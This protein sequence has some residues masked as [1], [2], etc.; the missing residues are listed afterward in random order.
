MIETLIPILAII[1][2]FGSLSF[3]VYM[4]YTSRHRERMALI[5]QGKDPM[6]YRAQMQKAESNRVLKTGI[7]F[8]SFGLGLVAGW[9]LEL[10]GVPSETAYFAMIFMFG[11]FGM[12]I[13]HLSQR[14]QRSKE[15]YLAEEL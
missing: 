15:D 1:C 13:Y 2:T 4:H 8:A 10:G 5:Q 11:G 12:I 3:Y 6:Q 9:A 7:L 14:K